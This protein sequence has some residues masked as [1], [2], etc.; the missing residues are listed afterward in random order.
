MYVDYQVLSFPPS[1]HPFNQVYNFV[2]LV[3]SDGVSCIY[4]QKQQ[5]AALSG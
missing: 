1:E 3:E 2:F 4:D 5:L